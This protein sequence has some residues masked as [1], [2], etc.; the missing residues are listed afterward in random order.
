[1]VRI[2]TDICRLGPQSAAQGYG[3][4]YLAVVDV[5]S[6]VRTYQFSFLTL[7]PDPPVVSRI[8]DSINISE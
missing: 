3:W 6:G 7:E 8:L 1:M 4:P 2:T 5:T